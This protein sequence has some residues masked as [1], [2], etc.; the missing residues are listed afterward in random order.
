MSSKSE[1]ITVKVG[2][3]DCI[4][5]IMYNRVRRGLIKVY[6]IMLEEVLVRRIYKTQIDPFMFRFT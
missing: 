2:G 3:L 5:T 1:V 4:D 6:N